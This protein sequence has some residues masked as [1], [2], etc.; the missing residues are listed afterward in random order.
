MIFNILHHLSFIA[1]LSFDRLKMVKLYP[2]GNHE[3]G[4]EMVKLYPE[5][6]PEAGLKIF[7]GRKIYFY[8]IH[9]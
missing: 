4:L 1:A 8:K 5:G 2:E 6:N 7:G 9:I 3:A